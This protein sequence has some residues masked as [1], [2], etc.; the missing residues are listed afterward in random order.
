MTVIQ[1]MIW[2]LAAVTTLATVLPLTRIPLGVI[3]GL[4]FPR[5]QLFGLSVAGGVA[6][7]VAGPGA[8][9]QI[10]ALLFLLSAVA[11]LS[12]IVKFT[13]LWPQQSRPAT[14]ALKT[15][16]SRQFSVLSSNVKMSNREYDRLVTLVH[17][18]RPDIVLALETDEPWIAALG[19]A[20]E[21]DYP[22][23]IRQPQDNGYGLCVMSK[24]PLSDTAVD[25]LVVQAVPSVRTT[26]TLPCGDE[27]R[28]FV[29][30]PEPPAIGHSSL[31]RDSEIALAGIQ[32]KESALPAVIAGDLNDVAWSTTTR[33]F[34]RLSG[35]LDP[36][37]G[38]GLYNTFHAFYPLLRWPLDHVFHDA[39]FRLVSLER[40]EHIGSD[41][42]PLYFELALTETS[43]GDDQIESSDAA[44]KSDT[45]Q[46]IREERARPRSP[47][48]E[49]W[50]D[51]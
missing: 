46:M 1:G 20:L 16:L 35:L 10:A 40:L 6:A 9:M 32:A 22:E 25:F 28:L 48:G 4:A 8:A 39:R 15:D 23:I 43:R 29:L 12:Y 50:E 34:Q 26:V 27:L 18:R 19:A 3:R 7:L 13:P 5:L 2:A 21:Q 31:G 44:E 36:R 45:R 51:G 11:H 37:V 17:A 33:R 30:H 42:F 49:D 14:D 24:L 41:H 38:R 47:I